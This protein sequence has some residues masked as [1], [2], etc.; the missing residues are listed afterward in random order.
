MDLSVIIVNWNSVAYLKNCLASIMASVSGIEYEVLVI[1]SASYDGSKAMVERHFPGVI[2]IQSQNNIGFAKANN[3]AFKQSCGK[4]ILF[5]N[6]DTEVEGQAINLLFGALK[7]LP[8]AGILGGKLLNSDRTIQTSC[9][10]SFPTI[11]NQVLDSDFLRERLP[12]SALWGVAPLYEGSSEAVSVDTISGACM[13][14]ARAVFENIG[15]FSEDFFMYTEDI[16]LCYKAKMAG[17]VNYYLPVATVVHHGGGSSQEAKSNF[18]VIM[19]RETM[20]KFFAN[21][22]GPGYAWCYRLAMLCNASIR[23]FVLKITELYNQR[24]EYAVA[25]WRAVFSWALHRQQTL[26]GF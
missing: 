15:G 8:K 21:T 26:N 11:I 14:M 2:F 20:C 19:M 6:P 23:L 9:I 10:Q 7:N 18:S 12:R 17:Y 4:N 22:K 1:D 3:L 24:N 25:K 5:I 16:D 13:M